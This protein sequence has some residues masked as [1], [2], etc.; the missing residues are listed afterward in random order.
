MFKSLRVPERLFSLGMWVV[1]FVFAYFLSSLGGKIIGELPGVEQT[2]DPESF[3]PP[4]QLASARA[5][6]KAV[7]A[8]LA[9]LQSQSNLIAP[10]L[11]AASNEYISE[12]SKFDSWIATRTATTDPRQDVELLRRQRAID[13]LKTLETSVQ[14]E[15]DAVNLRLAETQ[16]SS[17]SINTVFAQLQS[18][19]QPAYERRKFSKELSVFLIRLIITLP[20]VLVALWLVMKKRKHP[21]WPLARGFVIF[22]VFTF[23][24]QLVNYMPSYGGFVRNTV[25]IALTLVIA[26]YGIKAMQRYLAA[27]RESEQRSATERQRTLGHE[28]AIKKM[29]VGVCP[30]C[31]RAIAGGTQ[32]PSNFCVH[33]GLNLFDNCAACGTRKNSFFQYCPTCGVTTEARANSASPSMAGSV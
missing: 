1:S 9:T 19:A 24:V 20:L 4:E 11:A 30:G 10:R 22:A 12:K 8:R 28:E 3:I 15:L 33:C 13:S 23:F 18:D 2:V 5:G 21:Y 6:R 26:I 16:Q 17:D 7:D 14:G 29:N 32:S 25:G 27:R 31:E